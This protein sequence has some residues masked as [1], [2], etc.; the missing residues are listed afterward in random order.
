MKSEPYRME[1]PRASS[2]SSKASHTH[3]PSATEIPKVV[4]L[5]IPGYHL[6]KPTALVDGVAA[7]DEDV[8]FR[9]AA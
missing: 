5:A 9:P 2:G 7:A 4:V 3:R 6:V 1:S 8:L